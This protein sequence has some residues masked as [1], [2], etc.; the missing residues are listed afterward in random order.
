MLKTKKM[1]LAGCLLS[2][3]TANAAQVHLKYDQY[4]TGYKFNKQAKLLNAQAAGNLF[5]VEYTTKILP[6]YIK[7]LKALGINN[8]SYMPDQA[9]LVTL[10]NQQLNAVHALGFVKAV[11]EF[12]PEYKMH[13]NVF[14][15]MTNSKDFL[16]V[17]KNYDLVA[18]AP[19]LNKQL[20]MKI[21]QLGGTVINDG[22]KG[23]ILTAQ[24]S[25]DTLVKLANSDLLVWAEV[26]SDPEEDMNNALIQGGSAALQA[27]IPAGLTGIGMVGHIMEGVKSTHPDLAA[28]EHRQAPIGI[29]DDTS[30]SHGHATFGIVFASGSGRSTAKGLMPNGQGYFTHYNEVYNNDTRYDLN[31]HL[32]NDYKVMFQTASWGYSRT[33]SYD[34]R[35][36]EMDNIIFNLDIPITQSQSNSGTTMSRP[37]AW[38]KN[39]ISVGGVKHSDDMDPTNDRWGGGGSIGP[40]ED[41]RLKPDLT[42]YYD[43][44]DTIGTT[45]YRGFGGTSGATPIV[46]GH[47]GLMIEMYAKGLMTR[48]ETSP[49]IKGDIFASRPH[50]MTAKA[51]LINTARQYEFDGLDHDLARAHQGWGFPNLEDAFDAKENMFVIDESKVLAVDE[52]VMYTIEVAEGSATLNATMIFREPEALL[53]A[54]KQTINNLNLI[55]VSP[56]GEVYYGNNGLMEG[57]FSTTGGSADFINTVENLIINA[58]MA[59]TWMITVEAKEINVDGHLG[60]SEV[61]SAFSL[62]VRH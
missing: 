45:G 44:I 22:G 35:S 58:P 30:A 56:I 37:Q 39:I 42:A 10:D 12:R 14:K 2:A 41:G 50:A 20:A 60:T 32:I 25:G 13:L 19:T 7:A 48:D 61:D 15:E 18:I 55:A 23:I 59:G 29:R 57:M 4:F 52:S 47:L 33:T 53:T 27:R 62:V 6:K 21:S 54:S 36:A 16:S 24:L 43:S 11:T 31:E 34:A 46:A 1:I 26:S 3:M 8:F 38:A 28:N 51:L 5:I 17:T 40:S 49:V 9:Q